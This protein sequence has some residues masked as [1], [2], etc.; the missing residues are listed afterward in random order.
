MIERNLKYSTLEL[1]VFVDASSIAYAAAVYLRVKGEEQARTKIVFAK[2]RLNPSKEISIP[3]LELMAIL[4]GVRS[5]RFVEEQLKLKIKKKFLWSG[6]KTALAWISS[7]RVLPVF[8]A[9]RVREI[10]ETGDIKFRHVST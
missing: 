3:R 7:S 5:L 9:N 10:N 2:S 4:I 6:S 8:V 1:H